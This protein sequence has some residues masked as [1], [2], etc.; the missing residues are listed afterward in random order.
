MERREGKKF[1]GKHR[2]E[3]LKDAVVFLKAGWTLRKIGMNE[4]LCNGGN[5]IP[6]TLN[7]N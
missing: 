5:D 2:W 3:H 6:G 7:V 4:G 1:L